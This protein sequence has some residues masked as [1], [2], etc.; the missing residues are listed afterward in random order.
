MTEK[1]RYFVV[2]ADAD[3][4]L[5]FTAPESAVRA[6]ADSDGFFE[7]VEIDQLQLKG[8]QLEAQLAA[9]MTRKF[10]AP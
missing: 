9:K 4:C 2:R 10:D 1:L 7:V 8:T 5:D 3:V 6:G